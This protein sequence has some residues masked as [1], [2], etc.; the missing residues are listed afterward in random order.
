M[1]GGLLREKCLVGRCF[2]AANE[3]D[4]AGILREVICTSTIHVEFVYV[5]Q[6][7][8][9][10][11]IDGGETCSFAGE[12]HVIGGIL[13]KERLQTSSVEERDV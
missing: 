10:C 9:S 8:N 6:Y 5:R 4:I 7:R 3:I 13:P 2:H 12:L 1:H 11:L